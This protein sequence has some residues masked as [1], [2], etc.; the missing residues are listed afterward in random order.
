M[1]SSGTS[2]TWSHLRRLLESWNEPERNGNGN[3]PRNDINNLMERYHENIR[4]HLENTRLCLEILRNSQTNANNNTNHLEAMVDDISFRDS[5]NLRTYNTITSTA[6]D[7]LTSLRQHSE[8]L[9]TYTIYPTTSI[10]QETETRTG[11]T[12]QDLLRET[13]QCTF[14]EGLINA[15]D[16]SSNTSVCPISLEPFVPGEEV[17]RIRHCGHLFKSS[18]LSNWFRRSTSCPSCRY[19]LQNLPDTG[20]AADDNAFVQQLLDSLRSM[21]TNTT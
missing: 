7:R 3:A 6:L 4:L 17:T 21:R 1:N 14:E 9:F 20:V 16:R 8:P 11:L 19:N 18:P 2:D 13:I 10:P 12:T 15:V 5:R